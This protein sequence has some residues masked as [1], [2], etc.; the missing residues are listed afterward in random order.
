MNYLALNSLTN[1]GALLASVLTIGKNYTFAEKKHLIR[2]T[3]YKVN[4]VVNIVL[5]FAAKLWHKDVVVKKNK[6]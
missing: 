3:R 4:S 6:P 2:A 5:L 1:L